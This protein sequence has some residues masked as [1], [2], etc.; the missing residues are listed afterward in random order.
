MRLSNC[1]WPEL[2]R[3]FAQMQ[4]Q[5]DDQQIYLSSLKYMAEAAYNKGQ[6]NLAEGM[7]RELAAD[8]NPEEYV[9]QGIS[10]LAWLD[11]TGEGDAADSARKFER[12]L[13]R[14]PNS[15]L[16]AE[17]GLPDA[18]TSRARACRAWGR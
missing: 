16:A 4:T 1:R 9:A 2:Q 12:L 6:R 7:F 8:G 13:K 3:A 10:G 11:W 15:P 18:A 5:H 14:F 17:A